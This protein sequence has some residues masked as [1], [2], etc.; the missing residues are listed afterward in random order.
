MA[1]KPNKAAAIVGTTRQL[2]IYPGGRPGSWLIAYRENRKRR[3]KRI[4][5]SLEE[6][7][8]SAKELAATLDDGTAIVTGQAF[9]NAELA[10]IRSAIDQCTHRGGLLGLVADY[11]SA[12][13]II[14]SVPDLPALARHFAKT[15]P[16]SLKSGTITEIVEA[17]LADRA[18]DKPA[19]SRSY[20]HL[21]QVT[22]RQFAR[23]NTG[24]LSSLD[25]AMLQS[26]IKDRGEAKTQANARGAVSS[27]FK[28]ARVQKYLPREA[29]L[30]TDDLVKIRKDRK[31]KTKIYSPTDLRLAL[32]GIENQWRP[33]L[34]LAAFAGIRSAEICR[35]KWS[36]V[37]LKK[38]VI[39]VDAAIAKTRSR[40]IVPILPA[41]KAWLMKVENRQG[42]IAPAGYAHEGRTA[43][44]FQN[45]IAAIKDKDKNQLVPTIKNGWRH[46][47]IS[48]RL[49]ELENKIATVAME[50]GNS[51][52]V[53]FTNYRELT[54]KVTAKKW[55]NV[56]PK[57]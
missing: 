32:E 21:L 53:I 9:T 20:L 26:W 7:Q 56:M 1:T 35:L 15:D 13:K 19:L 51:E 12:E 36:D 52:S 14:G 49:E 54:D 18:Q 37:D 39:V 31:K 8:Q 43:V 17:Y 34:A 46:S 55:F 24:T 41:L 23:D 4:S 5:G 30:A 2:K 42:M 50:A 10:L 48:Y 40:R 3:F 16:D 57:K 25:A 11:L 45:A 33:Y 28:W 47:F 27:L 38:E 29:R 44:G 6:A 22:L